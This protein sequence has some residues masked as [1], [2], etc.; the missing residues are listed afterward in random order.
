MVNH[1]I[2]VTVNFHSVIHGFQAG[3]GSGTASLEA[4]L[5][6]HMMTMR[7]E[8]LYEVF[9]ELQKSYDALDMEWCLEIL[10]RYGIVPRMDRFLI[11]CW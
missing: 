9:I 3:R 11:L 5:L 4:N 8:F 1:Q 6:H 10:V 7:E 2:G